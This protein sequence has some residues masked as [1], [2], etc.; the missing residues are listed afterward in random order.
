MRVQPAN[1]LGN[2]WHRGII[3]NVDC[4]PAGARHT[5]V[6][7]R[8]CDRVCALLAAGLLLSACAGISP[9]RAPFAAPTAGQAQC[10]AHFA[11]FDAQVAAHGDRHSAST[12]V[13]GAPFLR[14]DRFLASFR[15]TLGDPAT[16]R[17][18]LAA[19]AALDARA[20]R[21]EAAQLR[22]LDES[23]ESVLAACREILVDAVLADPAAL[24]RVRAGAVVPDE[25]RTWQRVAGIY[26]IARLF[27][28]RGIA[29]LHRTH[30][31]AAAAPVASGAAY[32]YSAPAPA[33]P[34]ILDWAALPRD[35]LG[36]ARL[37]RAQREA[38]FARHAPTWRVQAAS[39]ADV[40]GTP[41]W[42]ADEVVVDPAQPAVYTYTSH[43]RF[44]SHTLLQ[45]NY[46]IW[47]PARPP[48]G[49]FDLLAGR[50]DGLTWRVTLDIDGI[51]LLHDVMHNCGCY[52]QWFPSARL[53][54]RADNPAEESLWVP[55][56]LSSTVPPPGWEIRLAPG[57]HYVTAVVPATADAAAVPLAARPYADLYRL[58]AGER[59]R[60]LFASDGINHPSARRERFVLWPFGVPAPG[61][62]RGIGHHAVAFVGRRH[63]DDARL[64]ERYFSRRADRAH[65]PDN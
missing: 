64:I 20:R 52:H 1:I 58:P 7:G 22:D 21:I 6:S 11:E 13:Q 23:D 50:L 2:G 45:L 54:R 19:L 42:H 53:R 25:Y 65:T 30:P 3:H 60:S 61:A 17:A 63:F 18:W 56:T 46:V 49:A 35:R 44:G 5:R 41:R 39:A 38:L 9:R 12:A 62:M 37:S 40:I 59:R 29:R 10:L 36:R 51:P 47:F 28:R 8:R 32:R 14:T 16:T 24:A 31:V 27:A 57:T 55:F 26:P 43:T 48:R 34:L 4:A 33:A 15:D